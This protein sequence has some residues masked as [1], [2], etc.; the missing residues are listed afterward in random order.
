MLIELLIESR[1]LVAEKEEAAA[2]QEKLSQ[3]ESGLREKISTAQKRIE[4]LSGGLPELAAEEALAGKGTEAL[5]LQRQRIQLAQ[6]DI[7]EAE[8]S[9]QGLSPYWVKTRNIFNKN[10]KALVRLY[11]RAEDIVQHKGGCD[12][13]DVF[14]EIASNVAANMRR[15]AEELL[16]RLQKDEAV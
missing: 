16:A 11:Q 14:L 10:Q 13:P 12:D 6:R 15:G 5:R 9:Q 1:K 4:T 2:L 7:E 8:M 3:L